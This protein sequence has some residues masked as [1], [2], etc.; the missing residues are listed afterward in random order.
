MMMAKR[1]RKIP[2]SRDS[3]S[4]AGATAGVRGLG[5]GLHYPLALSSKGPGDMFN[6]CFFASRLLAKG[7][8]WSG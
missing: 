1:L 3:R 4:A 7:K 6:A 5:Q 8:T 2:A